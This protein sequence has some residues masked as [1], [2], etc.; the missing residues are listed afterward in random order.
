MSASKED[1]VAAMRTA[2]EEHYTRRPSAGMANVPLG[3]LADAVLA[4]QAGADP[5][6]LAPTV[7][8]YDPELTPALRWNAPGAQLGEI[9]YGIGVRRDGTEDDPRV[10][11]QPYEAD[12]HCHDGDVWLTAPDAQAFALTVLAAA[13][14]PT[15]TEE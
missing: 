2:L 8:A 15:S 6:Q 1:L 14:K 11:L 12:Y 5:S 13:K 7:P 4:A 10:V 9:S 3:V